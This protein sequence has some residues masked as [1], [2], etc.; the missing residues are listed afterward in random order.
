M[1]SSEF[2]LFISKLFLI[3]IHYRQSYFILDI[4][5][6]KKT[7]D[8]MWLII[9]HNIQRI[10]WIFTSVVKS[11]HTIYPYGFTLLLIYN[12]KFRV[13]GVCNVL[14]TT[15][16]KP[17]LYYFSFLFIIL[18]FFQWLLIFVLISVYYSWWKFMLL[19]KRNCA[20]CM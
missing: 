6:K 18:R 17:F 3:K 16:K 2:N 19:W 14:L 11:I 15:R 4:Y 13:I 8:T 1:A 12:A 5:I 10:L 20:R 9:N 7:V